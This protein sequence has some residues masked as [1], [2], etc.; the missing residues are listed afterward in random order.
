M[1]KNVI[2]LKKDRDNFKMRSTFFESIYKAIIN[3]MCNDEESVE[4]TQSF[5][6][7]DVEQLKGLGFDVE[8]VKTHGILNS[9]RNEK[10][11]ISWKL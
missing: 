9:G 8:V 3:A 2:E 7:L 5:T 1:Y 10:L 11:V 4:Y 6:K